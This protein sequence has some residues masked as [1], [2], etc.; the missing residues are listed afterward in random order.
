MNDGRFRK[1]PAALWGG[2]ALFVASSFCAA[3][4]DW[5]RWRG[6]DLNGISKESGWST[7]WPRE[8][9][10]QLWKTSVGTGFSSVSVSNGRL[11]TMGN[12][13]DRDTVYCFNAD[14]GAQLWKHA[15]VCPTDPNLYEGGPNATPTIDGNAVFTFS[16]KGHLFAFEA[17]S[18]K[19]IWSK[20]L[21]DELGLEVPDWGFSGSP[22][23]EGKLLIVNA[24]TGG[25][26]V[27]KTTGNVVWS[28]GKGSAGYSSPVVFNPGTVRGVLM[29]STKE[30]VAVNAVNGQP[31]WRHPWATAYGV[32]AA[33]PLL[34]GDRIFISSGYNQ[35]CALLQIRG[36]AVSVLWQNRNMRNHFNSSVAWQGFVYGFDESELKCLDLQNGAVKWSERGLGK[37][38]LIAADGKLI[39]LSESGELVVAEG[40][41]AAFK[42]LAR[43]QVLGGK[44]WTAPVL[45]NGRIFCRNARGDL[46]CLEVK[47]TSA[48]AAK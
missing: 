30:L 24:G 45:S 6:P 46:V 33:E 3:A 16:R 5:Y 7:A 1:S 22:L 27:D 17:E 43:A 8:G 28:S 29:F 12:Y 21:H 41:Q 40:S 32:N 4:A 42:P 25:T 10:R 13:N 47:G 11:Y 20:N 26:A 23:V 34:L 14:T 38:S 37:G 18:G 9:P 48:S 15:Y 31:L 39:V 35:G 19:V 2:L 44:C 36:N